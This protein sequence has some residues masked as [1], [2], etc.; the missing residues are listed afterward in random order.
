MGFRIKDMIQGAALGND[1]VYEGITHT[2][3]HPL[4]LPLFS[5][6]PSFYLI[7]HTSTLVSIEPDQPQAQTA[8]LAYLILFGY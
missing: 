1:F 7:C 5:P 8:L 3:H 4:N 2:L 6:F